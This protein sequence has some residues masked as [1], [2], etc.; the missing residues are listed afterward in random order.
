MASWIAW[1]YLNISEARSWNSFVNL[2]DVSKFLEFIR[3]FSHPLVMLLTRSKQSIVTFL[4][5]CIYQSLFSSF[6]VC[7]L[8]IQSCNVYL[9]EVTCENWLIRNDKQYQINKK[10]CRR[11]LKYIWILALHRVGTFSWQ[12]NFLIF[13][14]WIS[15]ILG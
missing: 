13:H 12:Q 5:I 10:F 6:Y 4:Q 15:L 3:V 2:L 11:T 1:L 9:G 7:F 14:W 8:F